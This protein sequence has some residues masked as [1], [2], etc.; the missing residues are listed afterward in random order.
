MQRAP[1][2]ARRWACRVV[3]LTVLLASGMLVTGV[4]QATGLAAPLA[5]LLHGA[6]DAPDRAI[7]PG[8]VVAAPS[9]APFTQPLAIPPEI[10]SANV[11]LTM[12]ETDVPILPGMP[13]KM[14]T[15]NGT[16]P[17]PTIR[18]PTGQTTHVTITNNLP[19]ADG[20]ISTHNHGN[21]SPTDSD[22]QPADYLIPPGGGFR[23]YTY[24]EIEDGA[25]ERG[26]LQWYHDHVDMVT[27]RNVWM[28]MAGMYILDDPADPQTLPS[29]AFDVPLLVGDRLFDA[30]NQLVYNFNQG[31]VL[32]NQILVNGVVQPFFDVGT[33]KYRFRIL[34]GSN[35]RVYNL[36]L[37]NG[38]AMLQIGTDSGLLPAP[39]SRT[40]IRLAPAERADIV[41]DF[42]GLLGQNIVLQNVGG[43]PA[44]TAQIMQFNV[45]QTLSDP[46]VVPA[47]LRPLPDIGPYTVT[48]TFDFGFTNG[49]MTIN[50]QRF[51]HNTVLAQPV[52]G[53][54]E[55]WI[56]NNTGGGVHTVHIHDVDQQL[57]SRDGNPP[58]AY[59]L[60]KENWYLGPGE[61]I[62]LKLKFTDHLGRFV[63]HCHIVEH[64]D[65]GMMAQF[66]VIP[67]PTATPTP[68]NTATP[69]RTPTATATATPTGTATPTRTATP[70]STA[71]PSATPPPPATATPT[72][73]PAA[74]APRPNVGIAVRPDAT[75]L[76]VV[77]TA[78]TNAGTPSNE[79]RGLR[80]QPGQN[81][82]VYAGLYAQ[83]VP[84]N[85]TLPPG[86]TTFTFHVGRQ[87]PGQPTTASIVVTDRCGDW[88]TIIGGGAT[89]F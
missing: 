29:G 59:E 76:E 47:N 54:T 2:W 60:M 46:S 61:T 51:D 20:P 16:F 82:V 40:Q 1:T 37:S 10:T 57:L 35:A 63:F 21:H 42:A 27:G 87:T 23:T 11:N 77:L 17:G 65:D 32:G 62:E 13:T 64:E 12:A 18:R 83:A 39:V 31:G 79:L 24:P 81:A 84:F 33:R 19:A 15:F 68:T 38:Q 50:G 14:W 73:P 52:I 44:S 53:T 85:L 8:S 43:I 75:R 5:R 6:H 80:V 55:R 26:T 36:Q 71:T 34:N 66:E 48:R 70:S 86:T 25:P 74:C 72:P 3:I 7:N 22:G 58:A 49:H 4:A 78:N 28:G 88:P 30:N 41:I 45:T 67:P 56:F 9:L 89:A 69:T